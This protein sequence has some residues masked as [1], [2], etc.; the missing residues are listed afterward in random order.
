MYG[1]VQ[2]HIQKTIEETAGSAKEI[3][4][5]FSGKQMFEYIRNIAS[6]RFMQELPQNIRTVFGYTEEA[7]N[8]KN[9][10]QK[11]M[12][13]LTPVEFEAFLRPVFKEDEMTLILVGA[14]LG[15]IA[16]FLQFIILFH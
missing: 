14:A 5:M 4:E 3:I 15:G 10:L 7:L 12:T 1:I 16:G 8:L 13:Q 9:V 11:K 6:F 2:K